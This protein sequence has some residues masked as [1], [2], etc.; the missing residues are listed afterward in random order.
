MIR[1]LLRLCEL[2]RAA[3]ALVC[4]AVACVLLSIISKT[5]K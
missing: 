5:T 2:L 1:A 3:C 4:L